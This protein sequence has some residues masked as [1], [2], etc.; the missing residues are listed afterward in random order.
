MRYLT[1]LLV[2]LLVLGI[3]CTEQPTDSVPVELIA[4]AFD[5]DGTNPNECGYRP[6]DAA[7][8]CDWISPSGDYICTDAGEAADIYHNSN[9]GCPDEWNTE[10]GDGCNIEEIHSN[11]DVELNCPPMPCWESEEGCTYN[12]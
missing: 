5:Q 7:P 12:V 1:S 10:E 3:G 6:T 11:G 9:M 8:S 2:G 4:P